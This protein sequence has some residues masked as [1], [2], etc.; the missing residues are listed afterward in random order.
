MKTVVTLA[1]GFLIASA[2]ASRAYEQPE[3]EVVAQFPEFE[4]RRYAPYLVV[5]T[6]V[7]GDFDE[8]RSQAFRRLFS[9]ISGNNRGSEKIAMTVPVTSA[10]SAAGA[11]IEMTAPVTSSPSR[12]DGYSMQFVVP[13]RFTLDTV[14]R[15]ADA[16]VQVR[17]VPEA[18]VAARR[19]S[20]RSSEANYREHEATLLAA[21][22]AAGYRPVAAPLLAV[23]N[24][25]FTPWFMRRN[26]VLV[27][28]APPAP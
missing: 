17:E 7:R 15:P 12:A 4:V 16:S 27:A 11:T 5:E 26:E 3:Y 9:Y 23:Y 20:G 10:A 25:P 14:P 1:A 24:G 2:S 13:S 6:E 19:Y 8:A 22:A 28:V 18:L 21:V